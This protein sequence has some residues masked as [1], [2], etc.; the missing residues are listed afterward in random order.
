MTRKEQI[1][2]IL[3][4]YSVKR[5]Y[6][7]SDDSICAERINVR[8]EVIDAILALPLDVPNS[9]EILSLAKKKGYYGNV[10][11]AEINSFL[12]GALAVITEII[13]RNTK[14]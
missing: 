6:F 2:E 4:K 14:K 1:I 12:K 9:D 13:K 7:N 5:V 10:P 11:D 8:D 3:E